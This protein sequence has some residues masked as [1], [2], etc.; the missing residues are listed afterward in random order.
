MNSKI[1]D[2]NESEYVLVFTDESYGYFFY[3]HHGKQMSQEKADHTSYLIQVRQYDDKRLN[4]IGLRSAC[5]VLELVPVQ[6]V[7]PAT[8][9]KQTGLSR[10]TEK[11]A[12]RRSEIEK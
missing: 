7:A 11:P 8:T 10:F 5:T 1:K 12:S 4:S 6:Y 9:D 3:D 2:I